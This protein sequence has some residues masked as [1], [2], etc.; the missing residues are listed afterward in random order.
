MPKRKNNNL[1]SDPRIAKIA[2]HYGWGWQCEKLIEEMAELTVA[3]KHLYRPGDNH[4][5]N[6]SNFLEELG[7][8]KIIIA[9]LDALLEDNPASLHVL[10]ESIEYKIE[11]ELKRIG[12]N[13]D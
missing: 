3:I 13:L 1:S 4:R 7:D 10:Q 8:V 2:N 11:R 9:E 5:K 12:T 6:Y